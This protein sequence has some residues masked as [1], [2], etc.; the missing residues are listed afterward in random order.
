MSVPRHTLKMAEFTFEKISARALQ[1][2]TVHDLVKRFYERVGSLLEFVAELNSYVA[3]LSDSEP[4]LNAALINLARGAITAL[5]ETAK[6]TAVKLFA[7]RASEH[8]DAIRARDVSEI[9]KMSSVLFPEVP[10]NL[11]SSL[12]D[13]ANS[14]YVEEDAIQD[15]FEMID[16]LIRLS[17]RWSAISATTGSAAF[18]ESETT[19]IQKA[20]EVF[21]V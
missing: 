17:V 18:T 20:A 4:H 13:L 8:L 19:T 11:I 14:D 12:N 7:T 6:H 3:E 9:S 1:T 16:A 21:N 15:I 2:Y 10:Q 5:P